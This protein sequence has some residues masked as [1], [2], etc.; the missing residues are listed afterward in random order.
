[1]SGLFSQP[2]RNLKHVGKDVNNGER[3]A[4]LM[5][6]IPDSSP[7]KALVIYIDSLMDIDRDEIC[8]V[9]EMQSTQ[10]VEHLSEAL[11]QQ[12][13]LGMLHEKYKNSA[14]T[15]IDID[16]IALTPNQ[17]TEYGLRSVLD[18]IQDGRGQPRLP[19]KYMYENSHSNMPTAEPDELLEETDPESKAKGLLVQAEL[20]EADAKKYRDQ[21]LKLAP[22]L[23][24]NSPINDH[25]DDS[26]DIH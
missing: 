22:N 1:M 14:M 5:K 24:D 12:N 18:A 20:L 13:L 8:R 2:N 11:H 23:A 26:F 19:S 15:S 16:S 10:N 25:G 6:H 4:V 17:T 9:I 3:L 7:P 21:A